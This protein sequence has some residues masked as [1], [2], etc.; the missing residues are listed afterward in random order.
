M[1]KLL[2]LLLPLMFL[3]CGI[4]WEKT[5]NYD[6]IGIF[7]QSDS[8]ESKTHYRYVTKMVEER[9]KDA[10]GEGYHYES[11]LKR[12]QES[13]QMYRI[14]PEKF[15]LIVNQEY[16]GTGKKN[17]GD[18]KLKY[19]AREISDFEAADIFYDIRMNKTS[20]KRLYADDTE[21]RESGALW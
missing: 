13:Y 10:D 12:V 16:T 14:K 11:Q 1:K 15:W 3:S 19:A 21:V 9:V 20:L 5:D 4:E 2:L 7:Y 17:W 6:A 18:K 8:E